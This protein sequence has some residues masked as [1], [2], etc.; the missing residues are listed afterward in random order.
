MPNAYGRTLLAVQ[1]VRRCDQPPNL[2]SDTLARQV[3]R[4]VYELRSDERRQV[5]DA[6]LLLDPRDAARHGLD[7][8]RDEAGDRLRPERASRKSEFHW[9]L[10]RCHGQRSP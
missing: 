1:K 9:R 4:R 10:Y 3:R 8:L 5:F 2:G 6:D 7:W